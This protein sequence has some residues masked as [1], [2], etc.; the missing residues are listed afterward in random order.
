MDKSNFIGRFL[1]RKA[2]KSA[3]QV[4]SN[5]YVL[6]WNNKISEGFIL[7][8]I[9]FWHNASLK[10]YCCLLGCK[11]AGIEGYHIR[12]KSLCGRIGTHWFQQLC[13]DGQKSIYE[14]NNCYLQMHARILATIRKIVLARLTKVTKKKRKI[15][16]FSCGNDW[17]PCIKIDTCNDVTYVC[18]LAQKS[19][20]T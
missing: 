20:T 7:N 2:F 12:L 10:I 14:Q 11:F 17:K 9:T 1:T 16:Y 13:F 18:F 19:P 6:L 5:F 4:P 3:W 8:F 15:Y